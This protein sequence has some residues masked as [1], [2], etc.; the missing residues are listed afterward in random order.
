MSLAIFY[1]ALA[2]VV[3]RAHS[4]SSALVQRV[5]RAAWT[6][7]WIATTVVWLMQSRVDLPVGIMCYVLSAA[8]FDQAGV[9]KLY[10]LLGFPAL[11]LIAGPMPALGSIA[12]AILIEHH[13]RNRSALR[14]RV[15]LY[16]GCFIGTFFILLPAQVAQTL[17]AKMPLPTWMRVGAMILFGLMSLGLWRASTDALRRGLGTPDPSDP[18]KILIRSHIYSR[19]RHPMQ[20]G[21]ISAVFCSAFFF[22]TSS[23][24]IYAFGFTTVLIS[25]VR[26]LEE[27]KL[28]ESFGTAYE[29]YRQVTPAY[30]PRFGFR[31]L[32]RLRV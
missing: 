28:Q 24:L 32:R 6:G 2:I 11:V 13:M 15:A 7:A 12:G 22:N 10:L 19:V 29:I 30:F 26:V 21:H 4:W 25:L 16:W 31:R 17:P 8:L 14:L 3:A 18:T 27:R 20:L 9:N 5:H 23:S 1:M